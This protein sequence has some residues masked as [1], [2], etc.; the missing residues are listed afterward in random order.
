MTREQSTETERQ[1]GAAA[2]GAA[3]P[4][5]DGAIV[6]ALR[7]GD[8]PA[9]AELLVS[10][11]AAALGR[12]CMALLG[13][14][15]EAE[16]ALRN[17]LLAVLDGSQAYRG[18]GTLRAH[19]YGVA[20][21]RCAR[22]LTERLPE[23][24]YEREL[25]GSGRAAADGSEGA[26]SSATEVRRR[27]RGIRPTE[28]EALVLHFTAG[29]DL[30]EVAAACGVDRAAAEDRVSRGLARLRSGATGSGT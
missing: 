29:L 20:R 9:A 30:G 11:H 14:Q 4:D 2:N 28:R 18:V 19:L 16:E 1:S 12:T 8:R 15:A 7:S 25:E 27:L 5:E 3:A 6:A 13:S 21:R 17:T 22:R 23:R 10:A 26:A 24:A